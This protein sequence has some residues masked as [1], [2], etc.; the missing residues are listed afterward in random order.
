MVVIL[1]LM[2]MRW[3]SGEMIMMRGDRGDIDDV[4]W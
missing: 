1:I 4:G 2:M 3:D